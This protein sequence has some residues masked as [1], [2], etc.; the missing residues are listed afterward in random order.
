[1]IERFEKFVFSTSVPQIKAGPERARLQPP[2]KLSAKPGLLS[3]CGVAASAYVIP[4][5]KM[6]LIQGSGS[7]QNSRAG[8]CGGGRPS[9]PTGRSSEPVMP[10]KFW[11]QST[12]KAF[13]V[14]VASRD[15]FRR[16]VASLAEAERNPEWAVLPARTTVLGLSS[17]K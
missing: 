6:L 16:G 3:E 10:S 9:L 7:A 1:M 4:D 17:H 8:L 15:G 5:G 2:S 13:T 14:F 11:T 12:D